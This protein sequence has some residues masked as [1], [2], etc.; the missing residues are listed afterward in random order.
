MKR[1]LFVLIT[2]LSVIFTLCIINSGATPLQ[3]SAVEV[4]LVSELIPPDKC[5]NMGAQFTE[6]QYY[7]RISFKLKENVGVGGGGF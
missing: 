7:Y 5:A 6:D 4:K 3:A 2:V 1:F